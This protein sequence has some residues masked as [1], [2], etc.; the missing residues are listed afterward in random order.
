MKVLV[1]GAGGT[2]G[3]DLIPRLASS[4]FDA[5][6]VDSRGLD[7]TDRGR[8]AEYVADVRA[9]LIVNCSAYTGVDRAEEER[10]RAFAVNEA[11]PGNL[12][13]AA[14]SAGAAVVHI[15]TDYVFDGTSPVPYTEDDPV[16]PLGVYGA[17]KLAGEEKVRGALP[18]HVIIRT[19]WLYGAGGK[20]NFVKTMLRLAGEREALRVVFDQV[21]SPTWTGDLADAIVAVAGAVDRGG[22]RYGTYHYANEGVA[23]WYDLAV[24]AV[25]EARAAGM[26]IVCRMIEPIR[27]AEYP[28][29]AKRPA[30]SVFDKGKIR[31][32]FGLT[33]PHW[34]DGLRRMIR[35]LTGEERK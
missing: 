1:T 28:L 22:V 9:G 32:A 34:R 21:G 19:S 12:A 13:G 8:V 26:D 10:E 4:G 35:E 30:Y 5:E 7:V 27:T 2:L 11:G 29:P 16:N 18:E 23:S 20:G 3:E 24:A 31:D 33:I 6:A 14:A 15:S 25:E 17:S